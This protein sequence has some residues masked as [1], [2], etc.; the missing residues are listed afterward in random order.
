LAHAHDGLI[1][2]A[3]RRADS[4]RRMLVALGLNLAMLVAELVGGII[5]GSLALLADAAH[6]LSDVGAIMIGL[7]AGGLAALP[8]SSRRTFGYQRTEIVAALANGLALVAISVLVVVAAI[9]RLGDPPEVEGAGVLVLGAVA[10]GGNLAATAYLAR[11]E[12]GDLNLEAVIRHSAADA[13]GS[14]GVIAAGAIVL[15]TGWREADPIA[16]ILI[17]GLIM[18]SSWRLIRDPFDILME[19]AP[20]GLDVDE[21]G[22][23]IC[24]V[25]GVRGVHD[26]HVWTV[27]SG[28]PALAA[29]I[30]VARGSDR[31]LTL[32]TLGVMLRERYAIDHTTLQIEEEGDEGP[33]QLEGVEGE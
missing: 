11:G 10:F 30:V 3:A 4:R 1:A 6:L 16:S 27:T 31:D 17:A 7:L 8:G 13:L 5:T 23:E 18:A 15:A 19:A 14:L 9:D 32:R 26:L 24:S 25:P 20:A 29:H 2:L 33:L 21:L 28:F 12:R 22:R